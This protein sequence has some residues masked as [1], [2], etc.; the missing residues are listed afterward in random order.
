MWKKGNSIKELKKGWE[1]CPGGTLRLEKK[2]PPAGILGLT[3]KLSG[4]SLVFRL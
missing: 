2:D 3:V 4:G 1:P